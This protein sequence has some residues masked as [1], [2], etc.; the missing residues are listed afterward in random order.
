MEAA[1]PG[2]AKRLWHIVRIVCCML[3][4]GFTKRKLMLE[5]QLLLKRGKVA[6]KAIGGLIYHYS[7]D[8]LRHHYSGGSISYYAAFS[9]RS[10]EPNSSYFTPHEVEFSCSNTPSYP[11]LSKRKRSHRYSNGHDYDIAT[12]RKAME[13]V[14]SQAPESPDVANPSPAPFWSLW[15]SPTETGD[16]DSH[17]DR[18]AEDFIRRFYEQLRTQP[19]TPILQ[20]RYRSQAG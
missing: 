7:R 10:M 4:K 9:C 13:I 12:I 2:I 20:S 15:K 6:G 17:V 1:A 5:L 14:S 8:P 16:A 11:F 3:R 18:E 19:V